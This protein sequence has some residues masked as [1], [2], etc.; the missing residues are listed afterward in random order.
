MIFRRG[1]VGPYM[2]CIIGDK[3]GYRPLPVSVA[4]EVF[5]MLL[6]SVRCRG[7]K[8]SSEL[9]EKWYRLDENSV[10]A[11]YV[12]QPVSTYY[13]YAYKNRIAPNSDNVQHEKY[14]WWK[15]SELMRE[16]L[17]NAASEIDVT[18]FAFSDV[19]ERD[20][21]V[22]VTEKEIMAGV[23]G[24]DTDPR[25]MFLFLRSRRG[26]TDSDGNGNHN[27]AVTRHCVDVL[28]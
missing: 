19:S 10:P 11:V 21:V 16:A 2:A 22:S 24:D 1:S 23:Q 17:T 18:A 15:E 4:K 5:E 3:Y 14:L 26:L 7:G 27:D 6:E 25:Y 8:D 20:F 13:P 28:T 9:L 12:L